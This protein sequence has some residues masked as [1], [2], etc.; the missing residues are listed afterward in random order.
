MGLNAILDVL[1]KNKLRESNQVVKRFMDH[2]VELNRWQNVR[3]LQGNHTTMGRI[4]PEANCD[5]MLVDNVAS[6]WFGTMLVD[7]VTS[8]RFGPNPTNA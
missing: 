7:S 1:I 6:G 3:R 5:N 2:D 4:Q 8:G